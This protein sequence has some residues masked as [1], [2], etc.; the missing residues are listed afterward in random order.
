MKPAFFAVGF[1]DNLLP[2]PFE[3][4]LVKNSYQSSQR[5]SP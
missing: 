4:K 5:L 2:D 1:K 3:I